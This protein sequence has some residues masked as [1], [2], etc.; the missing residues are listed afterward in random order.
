MDWGMSNV[1]KSPQHQ[2]CIHLFV[3]LCA[4]VCVCVRGCATDSGHGRADS[5]R[6]FKPLLPSP[7]CRLA[8]NGNLIGGRAERE[9]AVAEVVVVVG[10]G[11]CGPS[12]VRNSSKHW[13]SYLSTGALCNGILHCHFAPFIF[14]QGYYCSHTPHIPLRLCVQGQGQVLT[15]FFTLFRTVFSPRPPHTVRTE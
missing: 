6:H 11:V 15:S 5:D 14:K 10:G 7:P 4:C 13:P 1:N 9:A 8:D 3:C 2:A 12:F